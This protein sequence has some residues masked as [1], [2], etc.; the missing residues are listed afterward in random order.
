[1]DLRSEAADGLTDGGR[2]DEAAHLLA[3]DA[4]SGLGERVGDALRDWIA[5][6][7]EL[8]ASASEAAVVGLGDARRHSRVALALGLILSGAL[9]LLT[10]RSIVGPVRALQASVETIV[11]GDFRAA[12]PFTDAKDETGALARSIDVLRRGAAALEDQRW[13]KSNVA[14]LTG[15]LQRDGD[16]RRASASGC[17]RGWCR[18]SAAASQACTLSSRVRP[19]C[20]RSLTMAWRSPRRLESGSDSGRGWSANARARASRSSS[21]ACRPT[22]CASHRAWEERRRRR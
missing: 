7:E 15:S 5:H 2:R 21:P 13:V 8:A 22:T 4:M 1:M 19:A 3:G 16:A 20:G 14:T 10:F 9:G 6:N 18:R 12:V 11:G 17:S